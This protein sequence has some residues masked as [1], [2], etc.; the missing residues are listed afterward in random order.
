MKGAVTWSQS[1]HQVTRCQSISNGSING[2]NVYCFDKQC[3]A[4]TEGPGATCQ[5]ANDTQNRNQ[6][7]K[8]LAVG[9]WVIFDAD[10]D[11]QPLW[12]GRV[13]SNDEWGGQGVKE[14]TT[15]RIERY[16]NGVQ[17][18]KNEVAINVMWYEKIDLNND[19][20]LEYH[21]CRT[22]VEP[23][24][25]SNRYLIHAQ[26]KM[27]RL[28]GSSNPMPRRRGGGQSNA[29]GYQTTDE[30]WYDKEYGNKWG[31]DDKIRRTAMARK[32]H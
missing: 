3:C 4:K 10:D 24:V 13:M 14:N 8:D 19:D 1:T 18:N 21:V 28:T 12:L 20:S 16:S 23:V 29:R 31:M 32:Q 6:L 7:A 2:S 25:Q 26:F 9:D 27:H 30:S 17:I 5:I 15:A 22:I 11:D